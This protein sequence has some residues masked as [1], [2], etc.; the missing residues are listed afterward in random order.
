MRTV[1]LLNAKGGSGK[2]TLATNIASHY[3][4]KGQHVVLADFDPQQSSMDWLKV[5]PDDRPEIRGIDATAELIRVP[6]DTDWIVFDVPS[7]THGRDLTGLIRRVDTVIMPVLPSPM[8][9][10]AAQHF[11]EELHKVGKLARDEVKLAL[12]AN[13]VKEN[14]VIYHQLAEFLKS[15][16]IPFIAALRDSQNYIKAAERGLGICEMAPSAVEHD[17]EQWKSLLRW[18][19]SKRSL[20]E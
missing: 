8:D 19:N 2:S 9:I 5:R 1:M 4:T 7:V 12:V 15:L 10:R 20:P 18:L 3:A 13:R 11:I 6:R 16:K 17:L 14:T